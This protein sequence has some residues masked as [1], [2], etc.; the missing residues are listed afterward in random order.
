MY[1]VVAVEYFTKWVEVKPLVNIAA[2]GLRRFFWQNIICHFR[3]P[4][5]ITVN[6]AK[7]FDYNIF[8]E[9]YRQM[10]VKEAFTTVYHPQF[11]DAVEI[12]NVLIFSA[13]KKILKDQPKGKWAEKLPRV[14][15][16]H[17]ISVC[18]VTKFTPFK[19]L[20]GK[21][22]VTREEIKLRG[23]RRKAEAIYSPTEAESKD[24]LETECLKVVKNLQS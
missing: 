8:K 5:K 9:F 1:A 21:E 12:A 20:Y 11:N 13:I 4:K 14:V 3:V 17:N 23:A 19:L 18:R 22:P 24:L 7:Q 16:S 2:V 15:W 10:G 6:N